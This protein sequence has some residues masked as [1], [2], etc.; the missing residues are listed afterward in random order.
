MLTIENQPINQSFSCCNMQDR[1]PHIL[2]VNKWYCNSALT[3]F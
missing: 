1:R 3:D 2:C